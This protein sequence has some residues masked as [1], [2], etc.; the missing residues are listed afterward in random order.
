MSEEDKNVRLRVVDKDEGFITNDGNKVD[1]NP[2]TIKTD[3]EYF[4]HINKIFHFT[5]DPCPSI[6]NELNIPYPLKD[7]LNDYWHGNVFCN[8]PYST[9]EDWLKKA[10]NERHRVKCM[11]FLLPAQVNSEW[12]HEYIKLWDCIYFHRKRIPFIHPQTEKRYNIREHTF[13]GIYFGEK[14]GK[15]YP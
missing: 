9:K 14:R 4:D 1:W 2:D 8:P 13:L 3:P 11:V 7:G 6:K 5:T 12:Y 15:W 10:W